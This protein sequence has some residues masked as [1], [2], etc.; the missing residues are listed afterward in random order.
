MSLKQILVAQNKLNEFI[1]SFSTG[2]I[3]FLIFVHENTLEK[4]FL[5]NH[6]VITPG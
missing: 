6:S 5:R 4:E 2:R 1:T 3:T